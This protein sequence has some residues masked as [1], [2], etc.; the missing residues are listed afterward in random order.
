MKRALRISL[1]A[2][3]LLLSAAASSAQSLGSMDPS[4]ILKITK[5]VVKLGQMPQVA[6]IEAERAKV[7]RSAK[8]PRI[9]MANVSVT[10]PQQIWVFER[11]DTLGAIAQDLETIEK[12]PELKTQLDR[13]D[14][15]EGPLLESKRDI[16]ATYQKDIS[17]RPKFDWSE[18]HYWEIIW[19]HLRQGHHGEYVENRVMTREEH[20]RGAFDTH[21]MMYAV[22]SGEQSGTFM[23]IR[24]MKTLGLLDELHAADDG[25]PTTPEEKKKKI[26]LFAA[27]SLSEEEAYFHLDPA[28]S[29]VP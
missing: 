4:P 24:P 21:Q 8:W 7:L 9:H 5:I 3:C 2:A 13:L 27:S 28:M 23:V 29:Y 1:I 16:T 25:E 11:Y 18:V 12:T 6:K 26:E 19:I 15:A 20:E 10:G 14:E 22:Q 17:Y